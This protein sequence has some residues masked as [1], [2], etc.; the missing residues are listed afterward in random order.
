MLQERVTKDR[1]FWSV[2]LSF[3]FHFYGSDIIPVMSSSF[4]TPQLGNAAW[5]TR[6]FCTLT[7]TALTSCCAEWKR[8]PLVPG[9]SSLKG[10]RSRGWS[11]AIFVC[12]F[13]SWGTRS[14]CVLFCFVSWAAGPLTL[15]P[16]EMTHTVHTQL[17][18]FQADLW[19]EI[20]FEIKG[21]NLRTW[22]QTRQA[23]FLNTFLKIS[24]T[25]Y[26]KNYVLFF[27]VNKMFIKYLEKKATFIWNSA[28]YLCSLKQRLHPQKFYTSKLW[29]CSH[30]EISLL[31]LQ[32]IWIVCV[33][34]QTC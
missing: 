29:T 28:L 19:A 34:F 24:G 33:L 23:F 21:K 7:L 14:K 25:V 20:F 31:K 27:S 16:R 1:I 32:I 26:C 15:C 12:F 18:V 3:H 6:M 11:W 30:L 5:R 4:F 9:E 10:E 8:R 13:D 17:L 2:E 22:I